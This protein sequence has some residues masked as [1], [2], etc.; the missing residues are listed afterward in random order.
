MEDKPPRRIL[1]VLDIYGDERAWVKKVEM[2]WG[3]G[4]KGEAYFAGVQE[5]IHILPITDEGKVV[6]VNQ[7][8]VVGPGWL[9]E[10]PGGAIEKL[11]SPE[12]AA[13]RELEEETGYTAKH[14]EPLMSYWPVPVMENRNHLFFARMLSKVERPRKDRREHEMTVHEV[15][16]TQLWEMVR[17]GTI[18][19]GQ[20]I[21][22][23]L[24]AIDKGLLKPD[25]K[26][27][28][29]TPF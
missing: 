11:E 19:D 10:I 25:R 27:P 7:F 26:H 5:S 17:D 29:S 15:T 9:Y 14:L 4:E 2:D 22:A 6:L 18:K 16:A 13:L 20:T 28:E 1:K 21:L 24:L 8:R 23:T 12:E 3:K